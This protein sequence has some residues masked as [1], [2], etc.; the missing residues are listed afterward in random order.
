MARLHETASNESVEESVATDESLAPAA[1]FPFAAT[2][3]ETFREPFREALPPPTPPTPPTPPPPPPF[4]NNHRHDDDDDGLLRADLPI[5][6]QLDS[7]LF[8]H[9]PSIYHISSI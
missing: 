6:I 8:Y 7:Y 9:H 1:P 2:F 3:T 5:L 4:T